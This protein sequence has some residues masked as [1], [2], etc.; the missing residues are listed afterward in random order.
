MSGRFFKNHPLDNENNVI[1]I[2]TWHRVTSHTL[3]LSYMTSFIKTLVFH[4]HR[5]HDKLLLR[6][7]H[8][9]VFL[10]MK[11]K[12]L[13]KHG[14]TCPRVNKK[15]SFTSNKTASDSM[16]ASFSLWIFIRKKYSNF[17]HALMT[18]IS[19]KIKNAM[20][21][22]FM[23]LLNLNILYFIISIISLRDSSVTFNIPYMC[24]LT[25]IIFI[26]YSYLI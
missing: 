2:S 9:K 3:Y 22:P 5:W 6:I 26:Y 1:F 13:S 18:V 10:R 24:T 17:F 4:I 7:F 20:S 19:H 12:L 16:S 23:I 8:H 25:F 11:R 14:V 15:T 21:K